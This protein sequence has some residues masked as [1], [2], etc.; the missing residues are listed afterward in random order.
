[1]ITKARAEE[2]SKELYDEVF[3]FVYRKEEISKHDAEEITQDTFLLF[4]EKLD[5]LS[6]DIISRWVISV[7]NKKCHEFYRKNKKRQLMLSLEESMNSWDDILATFDTYYTVS[8][9]QI[10][11][12]LNVILS[13]LDKDEYTLYYKKFVEG[14]KH[15]QIAE[16]MGLTTANV[17]TKAFRLRRKLEGLAKIAFSGFGQFI[18]RTFF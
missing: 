8:D 17:G 7:A 11:K 18:I 3:H 1:M 10:Q 9:E 2:L 16:E 4:Y 12:S 14:K 15:N 13:T 5:I 6:D